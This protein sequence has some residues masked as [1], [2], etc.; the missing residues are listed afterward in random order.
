MEEDDDRDAT[1]QRNASAYRSE[2]ANVEG[3]FR[4]PAELAAIAD[5][6]AGRE[7]IV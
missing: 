6:I 2:D 4:L 3:E 5:G 7:W 1:A